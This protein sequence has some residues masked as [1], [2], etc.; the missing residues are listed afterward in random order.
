MNALE[1]GSS[2]A[3]RSRV[4]PFG[5]TCPKVILDFAV[6]DCIVRSKFGPDATC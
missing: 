2:T 4:W 1:S 3:L 6:F 5:D